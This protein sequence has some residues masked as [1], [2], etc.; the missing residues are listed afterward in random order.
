MS[1][2]ITFPAQGLNHLIIDEVTRDAQ[3]WGA[4]DATELQVTYQSTRGEQQPTFAV[5]GEEVRLNKASVH[6]VVVPTAS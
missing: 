3:V 4:P 1:D 5:D 6:R 2:Y